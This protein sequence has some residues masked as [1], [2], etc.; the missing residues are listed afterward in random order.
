[1]LVISNISSVRSVLAVSKVSVNG[2]NKVLKKEIRKVQDYTQLH[3]CQFEK[4]L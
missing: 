1:M 4:V 2:V 3:A